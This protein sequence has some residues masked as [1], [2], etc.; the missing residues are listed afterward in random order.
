[1][2][3]VDLMPWPT[4]PENLLLDKKENIEHSIYKDYHCL[5]IGYLTEDLK[6][7]EKVWIKPSEAYSLY[8][9][10]K[11]EFD[12]KDAGASLKKLKKQEE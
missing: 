5:C 7:G 2:R 11:K 4:K 12:Y 3:L 9:K 8:L 10:L 1:M 6:A